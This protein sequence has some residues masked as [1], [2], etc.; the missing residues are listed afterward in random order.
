MHLS[1]RTKGRNWIK[2]AVKFFFQDF[3]EAVDPEVPV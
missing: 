1:L 3:F 2:L